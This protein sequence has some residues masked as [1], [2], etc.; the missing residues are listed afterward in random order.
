MP[1]Y[2]HQN[3]LD[4]DVKQII[5]ALT[6]TKQNF[7]NWVKECQITGAYNYK[8]CFIRCHNQYKQP[9]KDWCMLACELQQ[10]DHVL[11]EHFQSEVLQHVHVHSR[12]SSYKSFYLNIDAFKK[13][14]SDWQ[15]LHINFVANPMYNPPVAE[16]GYWGYDDQHAWELLENKCHD[17]MTDSHIT[18]IDVILPKKQKGIF[19]FNKYKDAT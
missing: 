11:T 4:V 17:L 7:D 16:V 13:S 3:I 15:K 14:P 8:Q 18:F 5:N 6:I 9:I 12:N 19:S 1:G 2:N 10:D